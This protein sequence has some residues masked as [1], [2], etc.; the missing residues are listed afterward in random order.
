MAFAVFWLEKEFNIGAI[1]EDFP[2]MKFVNLWDE[3]NIN[4]Y[5]KVSEGQVKDTK[6]VKTF[7]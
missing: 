4:R 1:R 5:N 2:Y 6:G 7:R 3:I